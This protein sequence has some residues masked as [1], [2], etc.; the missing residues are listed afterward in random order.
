MKEHK[1]RLVKPQADSNPHGESMFQD[2]PPP[3]AAELAEAEA[4]RLSLE[5]GEDALVEALRAA[6]GPASLD[7]DVHAAILSRVMS[8]AA[9]DAPASAEERVAAEELAAAL[10]APRSEAKD[11]PLVELSD[12]LRA[13]HRPKD[14]E[15]LRNEALIARALGRSAAKKKATRAIPIVTAAI[16]SVAAMAAG[17]TVYLR[18]ASDGFVASSSVAAPSLQRSRSTAELFE[19][20]T[21]FPRTGGE[22]ARVDKIASARAAELRENRFAMWGVR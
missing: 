7:D 3:S 5:R 15:P 8:G 12:A 6:H 19:A 13:A 2:E 21:P 4:L 22:S 20:T 11:E 9:I 18:G 1:L 14:I 16:V 17:V 10:G